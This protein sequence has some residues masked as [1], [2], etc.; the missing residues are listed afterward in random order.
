MRGELRLPGGNL[1]PVLRSRSK[2][3]PVRP[4]G[5]CRV[6]ASSKGGGGS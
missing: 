3:T 6:E 1:P 5:R 2:G 4:V